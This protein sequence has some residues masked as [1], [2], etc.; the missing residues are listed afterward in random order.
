MAARSSLWLR[1]ACGFGAG[2]CSGWG[3][4][5]G[6]AQELALAEGCLWVWRR[7]LL[8]LRAACGFGAG[9]CSGWGLPVGL[10]QVAE[11][12]SLVGDMW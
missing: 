2:A 4:P 1:A 7:S 12:I 11:F 9:A 8:W 5:V 10:A 3:L 6:L